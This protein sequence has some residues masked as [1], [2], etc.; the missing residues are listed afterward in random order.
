[1]LLYSRTTLTP[2][3]QLLEGRR[4]EIVSCCSTP[5]QPL[6]LNNSRGHTDGGA[7][8]DDEPNLPL[9][10]LTVYKSKMWREAPLLLICDGPSSLFVIPLEITSKLFFLRSQLPTHA[11]EQG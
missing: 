2:E 9:C 3:Q 10:T 8:S 1:M 7:R 4:P 11:S 6:L 5:E